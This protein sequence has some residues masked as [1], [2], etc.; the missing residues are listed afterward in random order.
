[1]SGLFEALTFDSTAMFEYARPITFL[2]LLIPLLELNSSG[3]GGWELEGEVAFQAA[4][5]LGF[6]LEASPEMTSEIVVKLGGP[7]HLVKWLD[8]SFE[9]IEFAETAIKTLALVV[10]E[11]RLALIGGDIL[12]AT[13]CVGEDD[14]SCSEDTFSVTRYGANSIVAI[15]SIID[16]LPSETQKI[17]MH[18]L[19]KGC[20]HL[21]PKYWH[22][23][24]E[25]MPTIS[26][27]IG[28]SS[29][30]DSVVTVALG[31]HAECALQLC[32]VVIQSV[33]DPQIL[34]NQLKDS[35]T[36]SPNT[37]GCTTNVDA[38]INEMS[39]HGLLDMALALMTPSQERHSASVEFDVIS[40]LT[41]FLQNSNKIRQRIA[42][43]PLLVHTT[44]FLEKLSKQQMECSK[45]MTS[46]MVLLDELLGIE[47]KEDVY[48][49]IE[50]GGN[51]SMVRVSDGNG[52]KLFE[53]KDGKG[54]I[55]RL[56]YGTPVPL[57]ATWVSD[58]GVPR[59]LV[60]SPTSPKRKS[61]EEKLPIGQDSG[62]KE[63]EE[64]ET[65]EILGWVYGNAFKPIPS[66]NTTDLVASPTSLPQRLVGLIC[67]C[68][69]AASQKVEAVSVLALMLLSK[70]INLMHAPSRALKSEQFRMLDVVDRIGLILGDGGVI[71]AHAPLTTLHAIKLIQSCLFAHN[72]VKRLIFTES[73][74]RNSFFWH[75]FFLNIF[76]SFVCISI[77]MSQPVHMS[78]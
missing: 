12:A 17:A 15:L 1:M 66:V 31:L 9:Q 3:G 56:E 44:A 72:M 22:V 14:V 51:G 68:V 48:S 58:S 20:T 69:K 43:T 77:S 61:L 39:S 70:S 62:K 74:S 13:V 32:C 2:P 78:L 28:S 5:C 53:G 8:G 55:T 11:Q 76:I 47:R 73:T 7:R 24:L 63:E 33:S 60:G 49:L 25:S 10:E 6:Y 21:P 71:T 18:M 65:V 57:L 34:G 27:L 30:V 37:S 19:V 46:T 23:L 45:L 50:A 35:L 52:V 67:D 59:H 38:I 26:A 40:I 16:F 42:A 29:E 41:L 64:E 75:V 36:S 54:N 4:R